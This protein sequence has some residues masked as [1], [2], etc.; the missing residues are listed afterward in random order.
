MKNY[1]GHYTAHEMNCVYYIWAKVKNV[2]TW[3]FKNRFFRFQITRLCFCPYMR[4]E[5]LFQNLFAFTLFGLRDVKVVA[6][7]IFKKFWQFIIISCMLSS[8][9]IC[10]FFN[11]IINNFI[12]YV[13]REKWT[14]IPLRFYSNIFGMLKNDV[15]FSQPFECM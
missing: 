2:L 14:L 10:V 9:A 11:Y 6:V 4:T 7:F 5:I 12:C 13:E 3:G 8:V 15:E 1:V